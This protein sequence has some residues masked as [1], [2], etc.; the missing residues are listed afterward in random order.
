MNNQ[1]QIEE[2][3]KIMYGYICGGIK[4]DKCKYP[5]N[6]KCISYR[7]AESLYAAGYR[8]IP[9]GASV[10]ERYDMV[11][12]QNE[13]GV[14]SPSNG[15]IVGQDIADKIRKKTAK[16]FAEQVKMVFYLE[17]DE[18]IPSIMADKIDELLKEYEK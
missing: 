2:M 3:A 7:N 13:L 6:Q 8:K 9:D 17:F 18:L 16:E 10:I 12:L 5:N 1:E 14:V 15:R 11:L 4:C